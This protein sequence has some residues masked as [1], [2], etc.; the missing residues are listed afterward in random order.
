MLQSIGERLIYPNFF[1]PPCSLRSP[2]ITSRAMAAAAPKN[3]KITRKI[4]GEDTRHAHTRTVTHLRMFSLHSL[5]PLHFSFLRVSRPQFDTFSHLFPFDFTKYFDK[6]ICFSLSRPH[7]NF[8]SNVLSSYS[9]AKKR[10]AEKKRRKMELHNESLSS[11]ALTRCRICASFRHDGRATFA[12]LTV[13][14]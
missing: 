2:K 12:S 1:S 10:G 14:L 9:T 6:L 3:T 11:V 5:E 4:F 7:S 13:W 8:L